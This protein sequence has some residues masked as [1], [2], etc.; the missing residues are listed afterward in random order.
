MLVTA[1]EHEKRSAG[2]LLLQWGIKKSQEYGLPIYL[3]SSPEALKLY[4]SNGFEQDGEIKEWDRDQYGFTGPN[5]LVP[6][7]RRPK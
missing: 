4:R 3:E 6:M 1:N 5:T 2:T 7:V